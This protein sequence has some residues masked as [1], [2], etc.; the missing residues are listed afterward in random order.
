M[1]LPEPIF[2]TVYAFGESL[3]VRWVPTG[4][5]FWDFAWLKAA[6]AWRGS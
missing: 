1:G 2:I 5:A 6:T 4:V 3:G